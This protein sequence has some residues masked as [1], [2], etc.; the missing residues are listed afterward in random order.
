MSTLEILSGKRQGDQ[1]TLGQTEMD[2]GNK[3]AAAVSIRDPWVSFKHGR[4]G[5]ANG[6]YFVEDL[7]STNGTWINGK[8][9]SKNE[10]RTLNNG[11]LVYFGKTK[12][13]F[14]ESTAGAASGGASSGEISAIAEERDEFKRM[15]EVLEKFLDVS[16]DQRA[17]IIKATKRPEALVDSSALDAL[18]AE[19]AGLQSQ[20]KEAQ[21]AKQKAEDGVIAAKRAAEDA[22]T[23]ASK[24]NDEKAQLEKTISELN[25]KLAE[26]EKSSKEDREKY[27]DLES[28]LA[29]LKDLQTQLEQR[30]ED[31]QLQAKQQ[32]EA[33]EAAKSEAASGGDNAA[34]EV[35]MKHLQER[36]DQKDKALEEANNSLQS[37]RQE[38]MSRNVELENKVGTLEKKLSQQEDYI[39]D[40]KLGSKKEADKATEELQ[41]EIRAKARAL[42][43]A[44]RA[45]KAAEQKVEE[46]SFQLDTAR[47]Q[48]GGGQAAAQEL[49]EAKET[50]QRLQEAAKAGGGGDAALQI[51]VEQI[52]KELTQAQADRD[53]ALQEMQEVRAE[54]DELAMENIKLEEELEKLQG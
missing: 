7:G 33:L 52:R 8:K 1:I 2:I 3:K 12:T 49:A 11:D 4:I 46:I 35:E 29:T 51:E 13:R 36:L 10:P 5:F 14:Q 24:F 47:A 18:K 30:L 15:K 32:A 44:Q 27:Q 54:I 34:L 45:Q 16:E 28:K 6:K 37:Q 42:E 43:D 41:K 50:I 48:S 40:L 26:Q 20:L 21:A 19:V 23:N 53:E 9:L 39:S 17:D 31:A 38:L 22:Q 25:D